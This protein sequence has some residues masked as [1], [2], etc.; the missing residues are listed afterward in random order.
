MNDTYSWQGWV[1]SGLILVSAVAA[2]AQVTVDG[3]TDQTVYTDAVT[4]TMT[5]E[6]GYDCGARLG[7][8]ELP[9]NESVTINSPDY[10]ELTLFATNQLTS[11]ASERE[12][13]F[14]VR[15]MERGTS[16]VGL[17]AWTPHPL[18]PSAPE[19]L[20]GGELEVVLPPVFP[21]GYEIPV[22]A[23]L[24]NTG[25]GALRANGAVRAEG[26]PSIV[27][28]RGV[29]SGF[30]AAGNAGETVPYAVRMEA[31]SR[32]KTVAIES[33][34]TW[35]TVA[36]EL[37]G[38]VD[39]SED[40]RIAVDGTLTVTAGSV[41]RVG[42]GS[43]IRLAGGA[44]LVID[45]V[46]VVEGTLERPV[47]FLPAEGAA[48]WGG[49]LVRGDGARVEASGAMFTGSGANAD[50]FEENPGYAVHRKEQ[51]L[52][53]IDGAEVALTNCFAMRHAGQFGHGK[54]ARLTLDGCLVQRFVTGGEYNGGAV[55][56]Y[57]SALIEF[58]EDSAAFDDADN[59]AIYFTTGTHEIRDTLIGWA[60]D[61]GIDH[62]S[63]GA[64]TMEVS[65]CWVESCFHEAF[66]WSGG[67]RV[68][69]MADN[70]CLNNGQGIEAGYSTGSDSPRVRA[71]HCLSLGNLSGARFGDNYDW[72]Y[73]G[74]LEVTNSYLLF[75]YRDVFG[76]TWADW[77]YRESQMDLRGNW[78][79]A[80]DPH[81]P[82]NAVWDGATE[83]WRL[84]AFMTTPSDA[85]V[86]V[87]IATRTNQFRLEQLADGIPIRLSSF[88]TN[89]VTV[90]Y[91]LE[92]DGGVL[93]SGALVFAPG[94][95]VKHAYVGAGPVGE[96]ELLR[97][98][99]NGVEGGQV[100]GQAAVWYLKP[101]PTPERVTLVP[102]GSV[103]SYLDDGSNQ[104]E[105][106]RAPDFD[107]TGWSQGP[108]ELGYGDASAGRPEAT[109]I[110]YGPNAGAKF[111]TYYFRHAFEVEDPSAYGGLVIQFQR[112]DGG[113]VYLNGQ[114]VFTSNLPPGPVD[115][116]TTASLA[117]DDGAQFH[118][119]NVA[120][121]YLRSGTNV[122]AVE[123][124]QENPTS[125]DTSFDL[126]LQAEPLPSLRWL[127]FGGEWHLFWS[128]PGFAL[129]SAE[130]L[131]G[132]WQTLGVGSPV[133]VATD[134][135]ERYYRLRTSNPP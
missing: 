37:S 62:G 50:W 26:Q 61:D 101:G 131:R 89:P 134:A 93:A 28:R 92:N 7:A 34:T 54:D 79:S 10:Y 30:L 24:W 57:R 115:Y 85:P 46:M 1:I 4:F 114:R 63:G 128:A 21:A 133:P 31:L 99:I 105:A 35:T 91:A 71:D 112:D 126:Q 120:G 49:F 88:T 2:T 81:H 69:R 95:T 56:I 108:A 121:S 44:D 109:V 16:E 52:F 43:V 13:R 83:G 27:M 129:E 55:R 66:A 94:E 23:R 135:P 118:S 107:D 14:I 12:I 39:W 72:T 3:L 5:P 73:N 48:P 74:Y 96:A 87:G 40:S 53:L 130:G 45:G 116:L 122:L 100:T 106:W 11:E 60:K 84:T 19:E 42:A 111:I 47:V 117:D 90:H 18:I 33:V 59:D 125:S 68:V 132:D 64:G 104:G 38:A 67:G 82:E 9:L 119:A 127:A 17:P 29:G 58:P 51:A 124:H 6:A 80:T 32:L 86:G 41:L 36:G 76:Y 97:I 98:R 15:D 25:G 75:N 77:I 102:A 22:V 65:G 20:A 8:T 123:V 110:S 78:L 70:V 113:I 103:W